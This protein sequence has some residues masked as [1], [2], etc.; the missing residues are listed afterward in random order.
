MWEIKVENIQQHYN[1]T[2]SARCRSIN[3]A[4]SFVASQHLLMY[5]MDSWLSGNV[6]ITIRE[7]PW[8]LGVDIRRDN[9]K[10]FCRKNYSFETDF[11]KNSSIYR[12]ENFVPNLFS[13]LRVYNTHDVRIYNINTPYGLLCPGP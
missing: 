12:M 13:H 5:N 6:T 11:S 2:Y 8:P 3:S 1:F 7:T 4:I 10:A 9:L